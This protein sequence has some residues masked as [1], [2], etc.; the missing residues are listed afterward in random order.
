MLLCIYYETCKNHYTSVLI[1]DLSELI[2][3]HKFLDNSAA[4]HRSKVSGVFKRKL[5]SREHLR[6]KDGQGDILHNMPEAVLS[7]L[8]TPLE[9]TP[10]P[11]DRP[12]EDPAAAKSTPQPQPKPK[13]RA[14]PRKKPVATPDQPKE[15]KKPPQVVPRRE[16][17]VELADDSPKS[18]VSEEVEAAKGEAEKSVSPPATKPENTPSPS[19]PLPHVGPKPG[20]KR[21]PVPIP[22]ARPRVA[23]TGDVLETLSPEKKDPSKLTVKEKAL[24]AQKVL[25]TAPDRPKPGGPPIPRKPKPTVPTPSESTADSSQTTS[26]A[27]GD[28][29][30]RGPASVEQDNSKASPVPRRKLPAGAFNIMGGVPMFGPLHTADRVRS[31]TT[32][33]V[34]HNRREE[35]RETGFHSQEVSPE[36]PMV[37]HED[38]NESMDDSSDAQVSSST[39]EPAK[40]EDVA[41]PTAQA[42]TEASSAEEA[43]KEPV[44]EPSDIPDGPDLVVVDN[45]VVL[46]WTPDVTVA[47]LKQVGLGSCHQVF[48]EKE[49]QGYMLFDIDGHKLKVNTVLT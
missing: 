44:E 32:S 31:A 38:Q 12:E 25:M 22:V 6:K 17:S 19:K 39:N 1:P 48:L 14:A 30:R 41:P 15:E 7:N 37:I 40:S 45:E 9:T 42:N 27:V 28:S 35:S 2:K 21:A 23:S 4:V 26:E 16:K 43:K 5:P 20:P 13:P 49:I 36:H 10:E 3:P 33:A 8:D 18:P 24:L 46:T 11:E 29:P 47:W 34:D